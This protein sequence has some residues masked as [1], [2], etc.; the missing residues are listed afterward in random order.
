MQNFRCN[1]WLTGWRSENWSTRTPIAPIGA[2]L[3]AKWHFSPRTQNFLVF[4]DSSSPT[5]T[6]HLRGRAALAPVFADLNQYQATIHFNGQ[7]TTMLDSERAAGV[8]YCFAHHVK[9]D[10]P[11]CT[12]MI[13]AIRYL[14]SFVKQG[15]AVSWDQYGHDAPLRL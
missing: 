5:P 10:G 13:A 3:P 11:T 2:M 12:L 15:G 14:D 8:A 9:V 6:Q 4:M 7:V 1:R